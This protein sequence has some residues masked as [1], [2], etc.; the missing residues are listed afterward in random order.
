MSFASSAMVTPVRFSSSS[1][2]VACDRDADLRD[3][4]VLGD[5]AQTGDQ[6]QRLHRWS[7][8]DSHSFAAAVPYMLP[9]QQIKPA[10]GGRRRAQPQ[11]T[12]SPCSASRI[13]RSHASIPV[14]ARA[15]YSLGTARRSWPPVRGPIRG[16][17]GRRSTRRQFPSSIHPAEHRLRRCVDG[18][19]TGV[20][21]RQRSAPAR[22]LP[23]SGFPHANRLRAVSSATQLQA[24]RNRGVILW[25]ATAGLLWR[26]FHFHAALVRHNQKRCSDT[27]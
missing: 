4:R 22:F 21:A 7:R 16:S 13:D 3:V 17:A 25:E 6:V 2:S 1:I 26:V 14:T 15:V 27:H 10:P 12:G 20:E 19:D 5:D 24:S 8:S 23:S 11:T 18:S 9:M